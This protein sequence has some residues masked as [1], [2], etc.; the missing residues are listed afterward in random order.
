[1]ASGL[2]FAFAL[3]ETRVTNED[4]LPLGPAIG[5]WLLFGA[6]LVA[7]MFIVQADRWRRWWLAA[8]D[9]RSMA[10][11]RIVF[12][13][14]TICNLNGLWEYFGFL[15]TDEG[16]FT[17]D[18]AR[19]VFASHQFAGYGDG[20]VE[21][22]SYGFFDLR[23]VL[24]FLSGPKYSLLYFWDSPTAF[25]IHL[26]A[27]EIAAFCLM[28]GFRTR[29]AGVATFLLMNS[30]FQ[31]NHLFWEGTELVYRCFLA[32]L[33]LARSG[34]AY[35]IDNWL[36]C[37]KLRKQGLLSERGGPGDGAG[38]A[39][40]EQHPQGLAAIYR[41]IPVWPRRLVM[42]QLATIY[43]YTG[44]VKNGAVWARGDA[45]Y[46]ALNM[47]HFYRFY[48]Q[49]MSSLLGNN[50]FRVMT[51]VTH[52]WEVF[53]PLVLVGLVTRWAIAE[54]LPALAGWRRWVVNACWVGLATVAM[55]VC[56]IAWPVHGTPFAVGWFVGGWIALMALIGGAWWWMG[57]RA[58]RFDRAWFSTWFLGRRLWLFLAVVFQSHVFVMMN[59]G[60]FQ[61][62]MTSALIPFLSG[63]EVAAILRALGRRKGPPIPAEDPLLPHLHRDDRPLPLRVL[64]A[65]LGLGIVGVLAKV[66]E[67]SF[68]WLAW[69]AALALVT[70][71]AFA[72]SR[73][74][75]QQPSRTPDTQPAWAYGPIGRALVGALVVWQ[76]TAVATW[77]LPDKDCLKSFREPARSVFAKWLTV[78]QTDQS[79]G[80]FAPNPPRSNVFLKVLVTDADG[81][82]WDLRTDVYAAE[83]KPIPWV[84]NDRQRKMNR[85][86]IGGESGPT[87]WYR[88]WFAR[89]HCRQW[90]LEHG[91]TAPKKVELVKVSYQ[92]PSPDQVF[93]QGWYSPEQLL[94]RSGTEKVEYTERCADAVMG[95]LSNEL[96]ERHGLPP[97]PEG[98]RYRP[99]VKKKQDAWQR[100]RE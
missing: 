91:G 7:L 88:K 35:S 49:P 89:Y 67:L 29:I 55:A 62:G 50:V 20:M 48:P 3:A 64:L 21:G 24:R 46:Y 79:W 44:V 8:D 11:F 63:L 5:W 17:T 87:D 85:R 76:L 42:L 59:I 1:M 32:I 56:V 93:R 70:G 57:H 73:R 45:F 53:F 28:I 31:R 37:R 81:E 15:F 77:L 94:E 43:C 2:S 68:W 27:F 30:I 10:L 97:L 58:K 4:A 82:V 6:C 78:T 98:Q 71:A 96:R 26:W 95:Q 23:A 66:G 25:W 36:R 19:Q 34:H 90:A 40:S 18:V 52:W 65:A 54:K 80:M 61:T 39:P 16:I 92:I 83:R 33:I 22:E 12:A 75:R 47:D 69:I 60:H 72:A 14:F 13:F 86:I 74:E 9:P 38:V 84:W 41:R 99:W 100:P 51:W